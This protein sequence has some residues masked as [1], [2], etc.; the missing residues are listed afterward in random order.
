MV[1]EVPAGILDA[2]SSF[3]LEVVVAAVATESSGD[4]AAVADDG[5]SRRQRP[6]LDDDL[7]R[8]R[9]FLRGVVVWLGSLLLLFILL[10]WP[11]RYGGGGGCFDFTTGLML[12]SFCGPATILLFGLYSSRRCK[13]LFAAFD[14]DPRIKAFKIKQHNVAR[15]TNETRKD[16][17][18]VG[19]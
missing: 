7:D 13:L 3:W 11:G 16:D 14:D 6:C 4:E 19:R 17:E 10:R 2:S 1:E 18:D 5:E 8:R 15:T 12:S 9:T